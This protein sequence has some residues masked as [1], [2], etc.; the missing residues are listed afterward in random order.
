MKPTLVILA[1]GMA[2]RYGSMK[3]VEAFGPSGETI[4][5]YSIADAISAGFGKIVFLIRKQFESNFR[6]L[7]A[8]KL[9]GKVN[10]EFA[11]QELDMYLDGAEI[12]AERTKPWGTGHAVLSTQNVVKEPFAVINA[13]DFYG[14]DSFKKAFGFLT[15]GADEKTYAV[16]GY[17]LM[18]TL[19]D[20]GTVNR[21]VCGL[22]ANGNLES[23]VERYNIAEQGAVVIAD[24]GQEPRELSKDTTVSMNF[25]C[26]HPSIYKWYEEQFK[27]F[28]KEN[29]N[30]PKSEFLI[31][32][33]VDHFIKEGGVVK[34]IKTDAP[35]FGVTYKEDAP[36]VQKQLND[37]IAQGA[38]TTNLWG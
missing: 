24:D 36:A 28:I 4:M 1:A 37:L 26:F 23:V 33:V 16:V 19:S 35:W 31:P 9:D 21:G 12:P 6:E 14:A 7:F 10:Y 13:D 38:Y 15:A 29:I 18:N 5:D 8:S 17:N 27:L 22:D 20:H 25:W 3:Q 34:V 2:S 30:V 32:A 11:F